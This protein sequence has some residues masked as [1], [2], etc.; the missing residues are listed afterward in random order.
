LS[1]ARWAKQNSTGPGAD[2][3]G[4]KFS[5][6]DGG[7]WRGAVEVRP[8]GGGVFTISLKVERAGASK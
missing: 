3:S 1:A 4:W 5:D 6:E 8:A 2:A 7:E